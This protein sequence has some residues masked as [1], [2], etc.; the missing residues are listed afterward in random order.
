MVFKFKVLEDEELYS[1]MS[2]RKEHKFSAS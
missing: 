2:S 1:P